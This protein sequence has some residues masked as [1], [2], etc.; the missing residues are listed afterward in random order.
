MIKKKMTIKMGN[1]L[2]KIKKV[3]IDQ[4]PTLPENN[5][6]IQMMKQHFKENPPKLGIQAPVSS[7]LVTMDVDPLL[8]TLLPQY[9][10]GYEHS[11][12][13]SII[14]SI[15]RFGYI[16]SSVIT[17]V[18]TKK[19]ELKALHN[20]DGRHRLIALYI[21]NE[22]TI[23]VN[24]VQFTNE[25]DEIDYFNM[26][27]ESQRPLTPEQRALN[28]FQANHPLAMLIYDLGYLNSS[29]R[30]NNKVALAG[31]G[32]PKGKMSVANFRKVLNWAGF[33]LRRRMEGESDIRALRRLEKMKYDDILEGVNMFH[34]WYYNFAKFPHVKGDVYTKDKVLISMLE[35]FYCAI[36]QESPKAVLN[37]D[38]IL[39]AAISKFQ[40]FN[41]EQLQGYDASKAPDILF[42]EFNGKGIRA[43]ANPVKRIGIK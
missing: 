15:I 42:E 9:Q 1:S 30:W 20:S 34:D 4:M 19:G 22:P 27:N 39:K 43:R 10:R 26:L 11:R 25:S 3:T 32:N 38:R 24:V 5:K 2:P 40:L 8:E 31:S 41:F 13:E 6:K 36:R 35:F 33:G 14:Q 21:L 37:P 17:V 18:K 16:D 29:S 7:T 23:Q 28:S 12:A